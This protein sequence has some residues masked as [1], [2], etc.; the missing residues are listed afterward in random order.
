MNTGEI[1]IIGAGEL[2]RALAAVFSRHAVPAA[3][4]DRDASKVPGQ[5]ALSNMVR[6]ARTV[7]FAIPSGAVRGVL[8]EISGILRQDALVL[9]FAKGVESDGATMDKVLGETVPEGMHY[10][11]AGG[12]ML[13]EEIASG[14]GGVVVI[15]AS[16]A[17]TDVCAHDLFSA[18]GV[19]SECSDDMH[20]VALAGVL[21]NI[22]TLAIGIAD[23]LGWGSNMKGW[24]TMRSM[25]EMVRVGE[26]LGARPDTIR[27]A[28]GFGD[29][30][31]TAYSTFSK[32]RH[33]GEALVREGRA[34][35]EG[36]GWTSLPAVAALLGND[37]AAFPLFA[38]LME[39]AQ[40]H[41]KIE[42]LFEALFLHAS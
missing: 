23:G 37:T 15:G 24:L 5:G 34:L 25:D 41:E 10:G 42:P 18:I 32:N 11:V 4:W 20:G 28:A 3:L 13:A 36:E 31:A 16:S 7:L 29:F 14:K 40:R 17:H 35:L 33:E 2:G 9:S 1:L 26:R 6:G 38:A 21:K 30:I 27:G 8:K 12:P 19:R 39:A 22:Y